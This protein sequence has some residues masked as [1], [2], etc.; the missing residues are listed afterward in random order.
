MRK[1]FTLLILAGWMI[2]IF[3]FSAQ[4]GNESSEISHTIGYRIVSGM[5]ELF[6]LG[7]TEEM[8]VERAE[9][10]QVLIRKGAHMAEY[11]VLTILVLLHIGGYDQKPKRMRLW[12]WLFATAYAATDEIHQLFVPGRAG[13]FTDV[14]I[15]SVGSLIGVLIFTFSLQL[16]A[17]FKRKI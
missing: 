5:N 6:D 9:E 10:M 3:A 16:F 1:T 12:G 2:L 17:Y 13:M 8:L 14:C 7:K 11:A 4:T 15:D